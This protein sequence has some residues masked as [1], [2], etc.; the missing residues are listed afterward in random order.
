MLHAFSNYGSEAPLLYSSIMCSK[1]IQ[2][3]EE[4]IFLLDLLD[5][6]PVKDRLSPVDGETLAGYGYTLAAKIRD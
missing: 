3:G 1:E 4:P 2:T 5:G 6:E